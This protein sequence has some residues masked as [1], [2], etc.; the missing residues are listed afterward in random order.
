M[1]GLPLPGRASVS[2]VGANCLE[3]VR[4]GVGVSSIS[5][6]ARLEGAWGPS[7][8]CSSEENG[9]RERKG[10]APGVREVA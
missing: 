4:V 2:S 10:L 5:S 7:G 1:G 8:S 3:G 6:S 9:T